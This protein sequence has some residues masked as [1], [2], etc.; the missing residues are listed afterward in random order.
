MKTRG[1]DGGGGGEEDSASAPGNGLH[2]L[3]SVASATDFTTSERP[4]AK[5]QTAHTRPRAPASDAIA[6]NWGRARAFE[7]YLF[8]LEYNRA[9]GPQ[10]DC[11]R[12]MRAGLSRAIASLVFECA[13]AKGRSRQDACR[14][15]GRAGHWT[16]H[17]WGSRGIPDARRSRGKITSIEYIRDKSLHITQEIARYSD[18]EKSENRNRQYCQ[19]PRE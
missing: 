11:N 13:L 9:I 8:P 5:T 1:G 7:C 14:A 17:F 18:R 12:C 15:M 16:G 4:S 6:P 2:Q 19:V 3:T 10:A